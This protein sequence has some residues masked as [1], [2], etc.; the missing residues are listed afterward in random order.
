[1]KILITGGAGFIGS[2]L[3]EELL[4]RKNNVV[5]LDNFSDY[6]SIER[7][8]RNIE[9]AKKNKNYRF[10]EADVRNFDEIKKI[11]EKEKP[12]KI[13]HLASMVGVRY[14]VENPFIYEEVNVKGTLNMLELAKLFKVKKFVYASSSSVYGNSKKVPFSESQIPEPISPYAASKVAGEALCRAYSH[15]YGIS[16][17]CLR[18]FTVYGPRGRPDM[19][20]YKFTKLIGEGKP[21]DVYGDGTTK[22]D[23][24]YI[25][26]VVPGI[27]ASLE[28]DYDYEIFN[29]G[30][31]DTV[32]LKRFI[33]II[34]NALGKKARINRMPMQP[35]DVEVTYA[36]IEKA[37]KILGYKPKVNIEEG[38]S[39]MV[40]WFRKSQ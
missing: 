4:S 21:I 39:E 15:L 23:Y 13:A 28:K 26:D 36:N 24:T 19:A 22:R 25:T 9:E 18:F 37:R 33:S 29:L 14:S 10:Y 31:S 7:K 1:M 35:G 3:A 8:K 20:P 2:H 27:A 40:R 12:D 5:S 34:E 38:I 6:Y 16:C 32:E 11:I 17:G 30:R